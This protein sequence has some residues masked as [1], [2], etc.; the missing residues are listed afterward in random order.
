MY[1]IGEVIKKYS[2]S[3]KPTC[4]AIATMRYAQFNPLTSLLPKNAK[5]KLESKQLKKLAPPPCLN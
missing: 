3:C 5:I 1:T 4:L 2:S